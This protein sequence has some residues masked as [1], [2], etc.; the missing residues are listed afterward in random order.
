M[1]IVNVFGFLELTRRLRRQYFPYYDDEEYEIDFEQ[2]TES[3][4]E[5]QQQSTEQQPYYDDDT[6]DEDGGYGFP[7]FVG[8]RRRKRF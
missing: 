5:Q 8:R 1:L 2:S 6:D 3:E 4:P 7:S